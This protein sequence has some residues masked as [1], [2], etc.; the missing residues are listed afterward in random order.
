MQGKE[1]PEE[2]YVSAHD[3]GAFYKYDVDAKVFVFDRQEVRKGFIQRPIFPPIVKL[4]VDNNGY[5]PILFAA[6]GSHGLWTAPGSVS[7]QIR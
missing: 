5:H 1:E 6:K 3:A 7:S 2:M 4:H